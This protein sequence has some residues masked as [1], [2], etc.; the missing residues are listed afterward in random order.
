LPAASIGSI[1][2][3]LHHLGSLLEKKILHHRHSVSVEGQES[4]GE[5][6]VLL[7]ELDNRISS[8]IVEERF[9]ALGIDLD[10]D[11][12]ANGGFDAHRTDFVAG[13]SMERS[14]QAIISQLKELYEQ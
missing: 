4:F 7:I 11:V 9:V 8:H 12:A 3:Q 1:P 13:K 2:N 6:D 10:A 14:K 5:T